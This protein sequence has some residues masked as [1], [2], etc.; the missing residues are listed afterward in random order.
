LT[1]DL[2]GVGM[3]EQTEGGH[4]RL[5]L[6]LLDLGHVALC[7]RG[8]R[9]SAAAFLADL[10][11]ASRQAVHLAVLDNQEVA[12]LDIVRPTPAPTPRSRVRPGG[13]LSPTATALGKAILA[14]S[15]PAVVDEVAA[16][17]LV[18]LT[19]N[20]ITD[21]TRLRA[22]LVKVRRAGLAF[23]N[24]ES[25]VGISC[26]AAPILGAHREAVGAVSV[27]GPSA[28]IRLDQVSAAVQCTAAAISRVHGARQHD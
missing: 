28:S 13:R 11:A 14:F 19:P 20:S 25:T 27:S 1:A 4:Y 21:E 8:L 23:D 26:C 10:S 15:P 16:R 24:Q 7:Q 17:G 5:G 2:A 18:Q 3:L 6:K 12:V 22:E 9:E